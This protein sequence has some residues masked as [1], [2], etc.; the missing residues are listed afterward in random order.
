MP[1]TSLEKQYSKM[2][3][4][5]VSRLV[6]SL[7]LPT[8]VS[9]LVT[10]IYNVADT[11]F[12]GRVGT[13]ASAAVGV[14]FGLQCILQAFG[15]M[16]GHGAGSHIA[17]QLGRHDPESA[18]V[19]ASTGFF[20]AL[21]LGLVI[22]AF[23][24]VFLEPLCRVLGS[25]DTILPHAETYA[26]W[27]L[28]A[29]PAMTGGCVTNNILRYE[30]RAVLA[31]AG[32]AGGGVLNIFLDWLFVV[33]LGKGVGGAGCATMISQYASL[34]V[35]LGMFLSGRTES[36]I[37][38]AALR[39]TDFTVTRRI[40]AVG[41]SNLARQGLTSI[42]TMILNNMAGLYGDAA[43][44]AMAI[45]GKLSNFFFCLAVGIGQGFQP[46][47]SFNYG[48]AKYS[49][50][51]GA[52]RTATGIGTAEMIAA[53]LF[54]GIFAP[55]LVRLLRDDPE[56]VRTGTAALRAVC[57]SL[58][59]MP[60]GFVTEMLFQSTGHA[61]RSLL[62]A[63]LRSGLLFIPTVAVLGN[64]FGLRGIMLAQPVA[65]ILSVVILLPC[66]FAFLRSLPADGIAVDKDVK[67]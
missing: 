50:V 10:S 62:S 11:Y 52:W 15:F 25:T 66:A 47:S 18:S 24:L 14:V 13:S 49:R 1:E 42:S 6:L 48:A 33:V 60:A 2:T 53:S 26:F 65:N 34:A 30:G 8:T 9:M 7:G 43:V 32:L 64:A 38:F 4:T 17:R 29:A 16:H 23:G 58:P 12:V 63:S 55:S 61:G 36:R 54:A 51:K 44:A 37:S 39:K 56:V 21:A 3:E 59:F 45:V 27:I 28:L 20:L 41:S 19:Y 35:L 57:V 46:V 5:P 31:M 22:M 67:E 40:W